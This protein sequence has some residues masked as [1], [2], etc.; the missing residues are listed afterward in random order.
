MSLDD[1]S[2]RKWRRIAKAPGSTGTM[3]LTFDL[4]ECEKFRDRKPGEL[5]VSNPLEPGK[6]LDM[7]SLSLAG[8]KNLLDVLDLENVKATFF[9][10]LSFARRYPDFIVMLKTGGHEI[11]VHALEHQDNYRKLWLRDPALCRQ[12]ITE[13]KQG[14]E[15]LVGEE[16]HG[17]RP[18]QLQFPSISLLRELGFRYDS[19]LHPTYVPGRYNHLREPRCLLQQDGFY[20]IP[21][22]VS[23]ILRAPFS[24]FWF[25]NLGQGFVKSCTRRV[26]ASLNYCNIFFHPWDFYPLDDFDFISKYYGKNTGRMPEL[27]RSYIGWCKEQGYSFKTITDWLADAAEMNEKP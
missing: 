19:S 20:E 18:P 25:R 21:I 15:E 2:F 5:S 14:L 16:I 27:F 24:W 8:A 1:F 23:P 26:M 11:G 22:S 4:E 12:R 3:L 10:T 9:V 13:A 6:E 17:F 7:F